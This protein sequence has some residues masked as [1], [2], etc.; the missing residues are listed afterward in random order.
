M[1]E[2]GLEVLES[3]MQKTHE[4]I[5]R[6]A[7]LAHMEKNEAY[8]CLRAVLQTLRDRLPLEEAVHFGAQLPIVLRGVYYDGWQPAKVPIKY[9]RWEFL[10]SISE[11][12]YIEGIIDPERLTQNTLLAMSLFLPGETMLKLK[13]L[14]PHDI[15]SLWP[16]L[17]SA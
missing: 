3:T 5:G 6:L 12:L 14:M 8:K 17:V 10:H 2:Q 9:N 13:H 15:Q 1:S 4:W 11:K 7:E 16:E